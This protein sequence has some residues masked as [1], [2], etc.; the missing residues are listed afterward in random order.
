MLDPEIL[1]K[2]PEILRNA[3]SWRNA[4]NNTDDLINLD[5]RVRSI[6]TELQ[7]LQE[8]RK[9][10]SSAIGEAM[11]NGNTTAAE[12]G[13]IQIAT[14]K[15]KTDTLKQ[16]QDA[17]EEQFLLEWQSI[18]NIP[19]PDVPIGKDE[20][21]NVQINIFG[22]PR[23][24]YVPPHEQIAGS[25]G[26]YSSPLAVK[27]SGTRFVLLSGQI[28]QLERALAQYMLDIHTK[29]HGYTEVS[30][31]YLVQGDALI[32]TGQLPKFEN[33]QFKT[34][35]GHYLIPTAEVTLT[36][37][38]SHM[39][40][41]DKDLPLRLTA[42]TPCFRSEAGSAGRDTSGLIRLHQFHKV[43]LVSITTKEGA[44]NEHEQMTQ[45]AEAILRNLNLP[46]RRMLLCTGDMGFASQKTF[47]L[48]V[49]MPN[50]KTYREISSCSTFGTFQA[51][52]MK[53]RYKN[54]DGN[55]SFVHTFNGSALAVGRTLAAIIENYYQG[56]GQNNHSIAVPEVLQSYLG[57]IKSI[58][59]DKDNNLNKIMRLA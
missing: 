59:F 17:A 29:E 32:G 1:R 10:I 24:D 33:D 40:L 9:T 13:K 44:V 12:D 30:T 58:Q 56:D 11:K 47:D 43:E 31:P 45:C 6:K 52:R 36:N 23:T 8:Q 38:V 46:Y 39:I 3:L 41:S 5:K 4:V 50:Q 7:I 42:H 35:S 57:G 53:A 19:S 34:T 15:E 25:M 27:M 26:Q 16:E 54:Q 2:N 55:I 49:W 22:Q 37:I 18:P 48:E 28:A 14:I 21:D 20:N 51:R